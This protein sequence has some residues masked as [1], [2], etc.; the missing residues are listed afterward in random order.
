MN[1]ITIS[2]NSI[3]MVGGQFFQPC[4]NNW[5]IYR[6][7]RQ[8]EVYRQ[9]KDKEILNNSDSLYIAFLRFMN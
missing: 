8:V 2:L 9:G 1:A 5:L 3:K 6:E 4:K 7:N